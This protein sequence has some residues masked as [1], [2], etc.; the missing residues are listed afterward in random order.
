MER[1]LFDFEAKL[2]S[3]DLNLLASIRGGV[4]AV[5]GFN[6]GIID[7][8]K[9]ILTSNHPNYLIQPNYEDD[10]DGIPIIYHSCIARDGSIYINSNRSIEVKPI[11]G[12][13]SRLNEVFLFATHQ[14]VFE[15]VVNPIILE[16]Y[17]NNTGISLSS[18]YNN[19][20]SI[21]TVDGLINSNL[22][23][24][25]NNLL[26]DLSYYDDSSMVLIGIYGTAAVASDK[27]PVN[28]SIPMYG[29][30]PTV[31]PTSDGIFR[32]LKNL[33]KQQVENESNLSSIINSFNS[34]QSDIQTNLSLTTAKLA[35]LQTSISELNSKL[36]NLT[37]RVTILEKAE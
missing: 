8:S 25:L 5:N 36:T 27:D 29:S 1:T 15:A 6:N 26:S 16:A 3:G 28:F 37:S 35:E 7:G 18:I 13:K 12:T 33:N 20:E 10:I 9:L 21:N 32:L 4:G 17:W 34:L 14:P 19:Y 2:R 11:K 30:F 22:N 23:T 31:I 24:E